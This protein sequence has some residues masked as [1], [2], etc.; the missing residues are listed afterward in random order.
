MTVS[1]MR[2]F[3]MAQYPDSFKWHAKVSKMKSNQVI[4]IYYSMKERIKIKEKER[5]EE[6][7]RLKEQQLAVEEQMINQTNEE[8][9]KYHQI[10]MWEYLATLKENHTQIKLKEV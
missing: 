8:K 7:K 5:K 4:A 9:E 3:L 10:D 2:Q 6:L 1:E